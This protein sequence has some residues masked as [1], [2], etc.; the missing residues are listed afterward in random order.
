MPRV[1]WQANSTADGLLPRPTPSRRALAATR[2][3]GDKKGN[4]LPSPSHSGRHHGTINTGSR[5]E[6]DVS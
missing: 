4:A 3:L 2:V 5:L 1:E 6:R